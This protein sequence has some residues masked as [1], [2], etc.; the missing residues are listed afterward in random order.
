M[1]KAE[2]LIKIYEQEELKNA[3]FRNMWQS[4]AELIFPRE[5]NITTSFTR[6]TQKTVTIYDTTA[7]M[8]SQEMASGLSSALVPAG[9]HFFNL[10]ISKNNPGGQ[11][12]DYEDYLSRLTDS[13][14][15]ALFKSNF[16]LQLNE[17]IRSLVVFGT[18]NLFSEWVARTGLNFKDFDIALYQILESESGLVD[19]MMI[20]FPLTARQAYGKWGDNIGEKVK[21]A[22]EDDKKKNNTFWFIQIVRP[23]KERDIRYWDNLNMAWE[24]IYV[25]VEDKNILE[26]GGFN[27]FPFGVPRWMKTSSETFGRGQGTEI[28][29][30]V[31]VLNTMMRDFIELGNKYVNPPREV[32]DSFDGEVD[33]TPGATNFVSEIP[34]IKGLDQS[35]LGNFPVSDKVIEM[36][37]EPVH[38]AFFRDVFVQLADLKGDRRTTVEIRQRIREGL[39]RLGPP[40]QRIQSELFSPIIKRC[41]SLMIRNGAAPPPPVGLEVYDIEFLGPLA[42]ALQSG[43]ARGFL[44]WLEVALNIDDRIPQAKDNINIDSGFRDLGRM[45]GVKAEHIN[46]EEQRDA[47]REQG[48]QQIAQEKALAAAEAAGKGY[49]DFSKAPEEGSATQHLQESLSA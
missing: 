29:P 20:K 17:T 11:N 48:A 28:L 43:Q 41:V 38:K 46:T 12:E 15:I 35:V 27:E 33:V 19:T 4:T 37:R 40:V 30:Q 45:F 26:E 2:E 36:Q 22:Y 31:R 49:K 44:Q 5:S 34:S 21:S 6:G 16:M 10:N 9:E 3:N 25:G 8:D 24:S 47:I 39:R 13:L 1:E 42:N 23:R 18:G 7:V 32:L 14:H